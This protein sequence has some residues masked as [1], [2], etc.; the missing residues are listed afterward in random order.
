[1]Q[2]F[3]NLL[4]SIK[5]KLPPHFLSIGIICLSVYICPAILIVNLGTDGIQIYQSK[6][7]PRQSFLADPHH[8]TIS[9]S[10]QDFPP[11][12]GWRVIFRVL[13]CSPIPH[14]L[15]QVLHGAHSPTLQ[16]FGPPEI[17]KER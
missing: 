7:L 17:A 5:I 9:S 14:D 8:L 10:G 2:T 15:L 16:F 13:L 4:C 3:S 1:M 12:F 6:Y 11:R